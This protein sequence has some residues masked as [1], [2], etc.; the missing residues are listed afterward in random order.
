MDVTQMLLMHNFDGVPLPSSSS[1]SSVSIP[2]LRSST[3]HDNGVCGDH[4]AQ[5]EILRFGLPSLFSLDS[6]PTPKNYYRIKRAV[7]STVQEYY[8]ER[9]NTD[10]D[11][12]LTYKEF[13]DDVFI[14]KDRCSH[15]L[16]VKIK[17][18][19]SV[20]E[21]I[22]AL[23][24]FKMSTYIFLPYYR[25]LKS[26]LS[27]FEND[28]CCRTLVVQTNAALD[29]LTD[30]AKILLE[31]VV[32]L[33]K[34]VAVMRVFA[35]PKLYQC[36]ICNDSSAE[37]HFLKPDECCGYRICGM[38][39]SK[40]WQHCSL[41]PVCPVCKTSFKSIVSVNDNDIESASNNDENDGNNVANNL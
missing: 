18:I 5:C 27:C 26:A 40:L 31:A 12:A 21:H 37:E 30:Q 15:H 13:V 25:Q 23:D 36:N 1:S 33:E 3:I 11:S 32:E 8:K 14:R 20:L 28:Y 35:E 6:R 24:R 39:L 7:F 2:L 4:R 17:E 38:C 9:Y 22:C 29:K 10:I 41:F 34:R 19:T 16:I